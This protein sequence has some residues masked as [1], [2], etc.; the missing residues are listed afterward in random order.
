ML[1]LIA[2]WLKYKRK[3]GSI[4]EK[5]LYKNMNLIKFIKRLLDC[6]AIEFLGSDDSWRLIDNQQ[7]H[8]GWEAVGTDKEK[9]PL[10]IITQLLYK[11]KCKCIHHQALMH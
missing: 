1:P 10:V 7:G 8:G 2:A 6:R 9:P 3:Q 11:C 4:V 5:S